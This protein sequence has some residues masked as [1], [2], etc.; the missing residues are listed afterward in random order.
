MWISISIRSCLITKVGS[1]LGT[2][3]NF[4]SYEHKN[5]STII[6]CH[7]IRHTPSPYNSWACPC[8][9]RV[10]FYLLSQIFSAGRK[11]DMSYLPKELRNFQ[12]YRIKKV[13]N[14]YVSKWSAGYNA[15]W[16]SECEGTN[17][18]WGTNFYGWSQ[19][20]VGFSWKLSGQTR[21]NHRRSLPMDDK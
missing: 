16:R 18:T 7:A 8:W 1:V 14:V 6:I 4:L 11:Q 21:W 2:T 10:W 19:T 17:P 12:W 13:L 20:R 15:F 5:S 9:L 3:G